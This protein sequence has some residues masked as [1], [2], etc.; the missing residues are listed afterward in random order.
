MSVL[1]SG[2]LRDRD[3]SLALLKSLDGE[4]EA[5]KGENGLRAK[6]Q[7]SPM[8]SIVGFDPFQD[9]PWEKL[10]SFLLGP[11][12]EAT[13]AFLKLAPIVSAKNEIR[14]FID[15]LSWDNINGHL[16]GRRVMQWSGSFVGYDYNVFLQIAPFLLAKFLVPTPE[17]APSLRASYLNLHELFK[18]LAEFN[19]LIYLSDIQDLELWTIKCTQLTQD[20]IR[21]FKQWK[22]T[23]ENLS[24]ETGGAG[25]IGRKRT[26]MGKPTPSV[27]GQGRGRITQA[28]SLQ[29]TKPIQDTSQPSVTT[30]CL[31]SPSQPAGPTNNF[32]QQVFS[33]SGN[34]FMPVA[35]SEN[36]LMPQEDPISD[37]DD[38]TQAGLS[39][40]EPPTTQGAMWIAPS[41]GPGAHGKEANMVVNFDKKPKFHLLTHVP[42]WVE[43][44]GPPRNSHTET[45]EHLNS[46]IRDRLHY[47]NRQGPS[48]DTAKKFATLEGI[49][50]M[51]RGG[52]WRHPEKEMMTRAGFGFR[53]MMS[54]DALWREMG[55]LTH[56]ETRKPKTHNPGRLLRRGVDVEVLEHRLDSSL[57]LAI[58][59]T[60]VDIWDSG[61]ILNDIVVRN[62]SF[63]EGPG[64]TIYRIL[65]IYRA[66]LERP[67]TSNQVPDELENMESQQMSSSRETFFAVRQFSCVAAA[68]AG[69]V[70]SLLG[71]PAYQAMESVC[72]FH[73]TE[74]HKLVN[75]QHLCG[76]T[77][78]I[79]YDSKA[80]T[81][82]R[83]AVGGRVWKHGEDGLFVFNRFGLGGTI[84]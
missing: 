10:H 36:S 11:A 65:R 54:A 56:L 30:V 64:S 81:V 24:V 61:C 49:T 47:S 39:P 50:F 79:R 22:V 80:W 83:K 75:M 38:G 9:T 72:I 43:R 84:V 55:G 25:R 18:N 77:C 28:R 68:S 73:S 4:T 26:R 69:P 53:E 59:I 27:C 5:K 31:P 46:V 14:M 2:V 12:K 40:K 6:D 1:D 17:M 82:E 16:A 63:V 76:S 13:R 66:C 74:L 34:G 19:K 48:L 32:S 7:I 62:G 35:N 60:Y 29:S 67:T 20:I 44:F 3:S 42:Y 70:V 33:T 51:S 58:G 23:P 52:I 57:F 8:F 45:E 71:C 37:S 21:G 41:S 15:A 78:G